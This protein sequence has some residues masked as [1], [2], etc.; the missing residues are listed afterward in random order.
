MCGSGLSG[1]VVC[2]LGEDP[3]GNTGHLFAIDVASNSARPASL[4]DPGTQHRIEPFGQCL[5]GGR[6]DAGGEFDGYDR[7][8]GGFGV[9]EK[10]IALRSR[11][12]DRKVGC[13]FEDVELL[14]PWSIV[15]A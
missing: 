4:C 9:N 8:F 1:A 3:G 12:I 13:I 7:T 15:D 14:L 6:I 2:S 5:C 11:C 10:E